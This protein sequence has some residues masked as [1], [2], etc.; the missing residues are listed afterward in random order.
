MAE[1]LGAQSHREG[2]GQHD[3][4]KQNAEGQAD[5]SPSDI[6]MIERHRGG[7]D[8]HEPLDA[9]TQ[10]AGVFNVQIDGADEHAP[11]QK[12]RQ[13]VANHQAARSR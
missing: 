9:D 3:S 2:Q 4:A 10:E 1:I 11:R 12:T 5:D 6:E 8:D 13:D 7:E